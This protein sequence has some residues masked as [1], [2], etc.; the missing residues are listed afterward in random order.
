MKVGEICKYVCDLIEKRS[1]IRSFL[2]FHETR[3]D[4]LPCFH[5]SFIQTEKKIEDKS[6][7]S[8][9]RWTHLLFARCFLMISDQLLFD[10]LRDAVQLLL[11]QIFLLRVHKF[12]IVLDHHHSDARHSIESIQNYIFV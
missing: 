1:L 4:D 5:Q 10:G 11:C 2:D 12:D 8:L 3:L 9:I 7:K 6:L